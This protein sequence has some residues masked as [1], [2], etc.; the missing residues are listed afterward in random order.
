MPTAFCAF[1]PDL[2]AVA[3][4]K[5]CRK[6]L[7][8]KCRVRGHD[9]WYCGDECLK[10]QKAQ[11][12]V[13]QAHDAGAKRSGGMVGLIVKLVV[14]LAVAGALYWVFIQQGVRSLDDLKNL[15]P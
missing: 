15:L 9:G 6:L 8:N 10:H 1:H 11:Q 12:E 4:C 7:C 2:E 5:N 13:V 14:V 3:R